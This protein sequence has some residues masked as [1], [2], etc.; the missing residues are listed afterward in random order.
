M[1]L[2]IISGLAMIYGIVLM[3]MLFTCNKY[4]F[5]LYTKLSKKD[6]QNVQVEASCALS[7]AKDLLS[8]HNVGFNVI[9]DAEK[10]KCDFYRKSIFLNYSYGTKTFDAFLDATYE[11]GRA[12]KGEYFW[13]SR[14]ANNVIIACLCLATVVA[15]TQKWPL[16]VMFGFAFVLITRIIFWKNEIAVFNFVN[17]NLRIVIQPRSTLDK[18]LALDKLYLVLES[19]LIGLISFL[20]FL[21]C[22]AIGTF[23]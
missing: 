4:I 8:K 17:Q 13:L 14:R 6:L 11:V 7:F 16:M 21:F 20:A 9:G 23:L 18:M 5:K 1:N 2:L 10:S 3:V 22:Y 12:V 19:I 15:G